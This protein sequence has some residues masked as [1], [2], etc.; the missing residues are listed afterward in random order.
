M[1]EWSKDYWF[2]MVLWMKGKFGTVVS[3]YADHCNENKDFTV[4]VNQRALLVSRN[5]EK[6]LK[7]NIENK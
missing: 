7:S 1:R 3:R 6:N 4:L 5:V 2:A